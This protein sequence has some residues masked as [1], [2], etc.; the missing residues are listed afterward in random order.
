MVLSDNVIFGRYPSYNLH[1]SQLGQSRKTFL[2]A[3][4]FLYLGKIVFL[5]IYFYATRTSNCI[6][7]KR[8]TQNVIVNTL[9]L[10]QLPSAYFFFK[11]GY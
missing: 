10:K 3:L 9:F 4:T 7:R 11:S 1:S 5:F 2:H 8:Q 6:S